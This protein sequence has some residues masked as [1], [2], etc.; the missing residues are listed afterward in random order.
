MSS[1]GGA[2]VTNQIAYAIHMRIRRAIQA[3]EP[4]RCIIVFPQPEE[5]GRWA[6]P[7]LQRELRTASSLL[8]RISL[9]FPDVVVSDYVE[10]F[11]LRSHGYLHGEPVTDQIFV[12]SKMM[13][14]DD[15][16]AIVGKADKQVK[17]QNEGKQILIMDR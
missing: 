6:V 15:R 2:G 5:V 3:K 13:I 7:T 12:H 16:I 4:F 11:Q 10:F 8:E 1:Y 17:Y 14:V 9:E